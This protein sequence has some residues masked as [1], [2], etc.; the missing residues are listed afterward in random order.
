[1]AG[2]ITEIP[3]ICAICGELFGR[4]RSPSGR[5]ES[6]FSFNKRRYCSRSCADKRVPYWLGRKRLDMVGSGNPSWVGGRTK[7]MAGYVYIYQPNHPKAQHGKYV[8][9][10]ILVIEKQIGRYLR[11]DEVV[12]HI[13]GI[14]DDNRPENLRLVRHNAHFEERECPKCNYKWWTR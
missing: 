14:K 6:N 13:N 10:Q 12:H 3:K 4:R 11:G 9:E 8:P 2:R 5:L 7:S 1:M